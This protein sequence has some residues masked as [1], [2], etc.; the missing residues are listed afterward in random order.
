LTKYVD[1]NLNNNEDI[2]KLND[3]KNLWEEKNDKNEMVDQTFIENYLK[4]LENK[5]MK[6]DLNET[7]K[8][9]ILCH[10]FSSNKYENRN[11]ENFFKKNDQNN[12]D[13]PKN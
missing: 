1:F 4:E 2:I 3:I 10:L 5:I 9:K 13:I 8:D 6:K 7:I 12:D 11:S